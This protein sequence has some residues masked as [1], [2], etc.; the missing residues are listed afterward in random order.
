MNL[1]QKF[2]AAAVDSQQSARMSANSNN[3]NNKNNEDVSTDDE[4]LNEILQGFANLRDRVAANITCC[5]TIFEN[6]DEQLVVLMS[7]AIGLKSHDGREL[8]NTDLEP[9]K[10][11]KFRKKVNPTVKHLKQEIKRRSMAKGADERG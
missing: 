7:M 8:G 3:N 9:Y 4:S 11:M 6:S 10:S 5:K 2:D 1:I